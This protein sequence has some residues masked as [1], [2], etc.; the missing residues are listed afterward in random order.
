[1]N[2]AQLNGLRMY[3]DTLHKE[4]QDKFILYRRV[5]GKDRVIAFD[6]NYEQ[7]LLWKSFY[8]DSF[9]KRMEV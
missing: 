9:I 7:A 2:T 8:A 3:A 4:N 1:M 5:N 6:L